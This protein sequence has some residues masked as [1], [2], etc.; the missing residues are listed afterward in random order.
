MRLHV[1]C[2][3]SG[4]MGGRELANCAISVV[5]L[6]GRMAKQIEHVKSA[7]VEAPPTAPKIGT[8]SALAGEELAIGADV[9]D[10]GP[11][12]D[13]HGRRGQDQRRRLDQG[14]DGRAP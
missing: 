9:P 14:L 5:M 7:K 1:V 13:G 11:E 4:S 12:G 6:L 2:D 8:L 3:I 10:A